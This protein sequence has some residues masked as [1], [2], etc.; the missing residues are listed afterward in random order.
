MLTLIVR[1]LLLPDDLACLPYLP[2]D[3]SA[4]NDSWAQR[5]LTENYRQPRFVL[6]QARPAVRVKQPSDKSSR[7]SRDNH[8]CNERR[9]AGEQS[10]DNAS[11]LRPLLAW[12]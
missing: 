2:A 10:P 4:G 6:A 3:V 8:D 9:E 11:E 12:L 7:R 1:H 5:V